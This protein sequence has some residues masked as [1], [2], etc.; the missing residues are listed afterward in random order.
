LTP[1]NSTG[2][3]D[4]E[5]VKEYY[6]TKEEVVRKAKEFATLLRNSRHFVVYTGAG[7]STA[8]RIPDYRGPQGVWTLQ[9]RGMASR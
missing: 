6:D 9:A 8:A 2:A 7:I 4:E 3:P 1:A 5:E